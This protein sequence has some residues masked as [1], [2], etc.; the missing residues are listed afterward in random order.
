MDALSAVGQCDLA[1]VNEVICS[2]KKQ[3]FTF[4]MAL[5]SVIVG[6]TVM[7][8][9]V[10]YVSSRYIMRTGFLPVV[11]ETILWLEL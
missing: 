2:V 9:G 8:A 6:A 5:H 10:G 7:S 1:G 11:T 3:A 4:T